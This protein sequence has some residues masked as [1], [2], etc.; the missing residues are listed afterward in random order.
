MPYYDFTLEAGDIFFNPPCWWHHV[1]NETMSI[2]IG[3]RWFEPITSL[4]A[5][6]MQT[7]LT[8]LA[9]NPNVVQ[10]TLNR[11]NFPKIFSYIHEKQH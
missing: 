6:G 5:S 4:K 7:L 1:M 8:L 3:F 9:T 11:T 2:G 10:A